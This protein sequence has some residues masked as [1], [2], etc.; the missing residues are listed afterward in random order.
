MLPVLRVNAVRATPTL[1]R[2][3]ATEKQILNRIKTTTSIAKITK[4][5]K[6]VSAAKLKGVQSRLKESLPF[7]RWADQLYGKPLD[8]DVKGEEIATS[9]GTSTLLVPITSDRGLCGS[10]N[11]QITRV[12]ARFVP[13]MAA[14]NKDFKILVLGEKGRGQLRR[15]Y[16]SRMVGALT[17]YTKGNVSFITASALSEEILKQDF[18]NV[19]VMYNQF[20]SALSNI[21][22][23]RNIKKE[24]YDGEVEPLGDYEFDPEPK[25]EF[26]QDLFEYQLASG[27]HCAI[28]H[29]ATSEQSTRMT[30][31]D[32]AT[33]NAKEMI[34]KLKL[35]YNRARQS[36]ITTE[37]TEIISGAAALETKD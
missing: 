26:L 12:I 6:M 28:M 8:V 23:I 30:A 5:M 7:C 9:A 14:Q 11:S 24:D 4:S 19:F 10:V 20:F 21:P 18:S 2:G 22:H 32:N 13:V 31:M 35:R 3:M 37:L 17:D 1:A 29:G 25:E 16:G 34:D 33:K 27:L 36:R 15:R